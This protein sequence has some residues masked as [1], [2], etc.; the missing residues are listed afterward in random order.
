MALAGAPQTFFM[1]QLVNDVLDVGAMFLMKDI[2]RLAMAVFFI[3]FFFHL[4]AGAGELAE[5]PATCRFFKSRWWL[6]I[7]FCLALLIGYRP[8]F[9][10]FAR[11][12]LPAFMTSF[13]GS[14]LE[15]WNGELDAK[16]QLLKMH[17]DNQDVKQAEVTTTRQGGEDQAWWSKAMAW[18]VDALI[19]ALGIVLSTLAGMFITVLILIQGFWVLGVNVVILGLGPLCIA[20]LAHEA[21]EGI[22]W[23]W[24]KAWLIYG[25][26]YLPM[27]GLG[28]RLAGVVFKG[29]TTMVA[30]SSVVFGDGSDIAMHFIYALLGPLCSLAVFQ[31]IPSLLS[32]LLA[33]AGGGGSWAA[34]PA[35]AAATATADVA[36]QGMKGS[37][38]VSGGPGPLPTPSQGGQGR[39]ALAEALGVKPGERS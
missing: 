14:W 1:D 29:I 10:G 28:A 39:T 19:T 34:A 12:A 35:A 25:L 8:M 24:A 32:N 17:H 20:F 4:V 36:N 5:A 26:L 16:D 31:A 37:L 30:G 22:F 23:T 18:T 38:V 11:S 9:E 21:T 7:A 33:S 13:G 3:C 27:L 6:R 2:T 15:I